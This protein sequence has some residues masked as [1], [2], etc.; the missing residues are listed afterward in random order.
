[1]NLAKLNNLQ[2][3]AAP[4]RC[5]TL[6]VCFRTDREAIAALLP[7][8]LRADGSAAATLQFSATPAAD[9]RGVDIETRLAVDAELDGIPVAFVAR[10]WV[11]EWPADGEDEACL[12]PG[13]AR[14]IEF[15]DRLAGVLESGGR[16]I[17]VASVARRSRLL[18]ASTPRYPAAAAAT[19]MARPQVSL[20]R[21][22]G[23]GGPLESRLIRRTV[24]GIEVREAHGGAAELELA[25]VG[26]FLPPHTVL[27][28]VHIIADI[29]P[30]PS[31][32]PGDFQPRAAGRLRQH[33]EE[34]CA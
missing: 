5:E 24:E 31:G 21:S 17:A 28:G 2:P 25:A 11:V 26:G 23:R 29:L 9:G 3:A 4:R 8:P 34:A 16:A 15:H 1:M 27:G 30:G 32:T 12:V 6:L 14:L 10:R 18:D 13:R 20:R 22:A 7:A 33:I 19:W